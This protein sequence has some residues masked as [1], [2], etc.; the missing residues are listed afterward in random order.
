MGIAGCGG[1]WKGDGGVKGVNTSS[2]VSERFSPDVI[3][4]FRL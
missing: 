3:E 1:T 2:I 4:G